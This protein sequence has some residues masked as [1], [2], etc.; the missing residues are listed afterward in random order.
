MTESLL[1]KSLINVATFVGLAVPLVGLGMYVNNLTNQIDTSKAEVAAL[2]AQVG[3]L[4]DL[5][6]QTQAIASGERGPKG[7]KG[8]T[9]DQGARGE[10]GPQGEMGPM[11]PSGTTGG[12]SEQQIRQLVE[13][14]IQQKISALPTSTTNP[15]GGALSETDA[16][17]TSGCISVDNIRNLEMLPLREGQEFCDGNGRLLARVG[18]F[19]RNGWFKMTR[20]GTASDSCTLERSCTLR[21]LNGKSYVYERLGQDDKGQVALLRLQS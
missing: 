14:A 9:G 18:E 11:G 10:R 8:D 12:M 15:I 3:Q 16:F 4:Q 21:W 2:K 1:N 19:S 6:Q 17:Q 20:P 7:D 13:Q 5:L